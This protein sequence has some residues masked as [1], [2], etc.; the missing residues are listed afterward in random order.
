MRIRAKISFFVIPLTMLPLLLVGLY[1]YQSL[2]TGFEE[3]AY[4]DDQQ[5]CLM[6][7]MRIEQAL[8]ECHDGLSLLTTLLL[9]HL[10]QP[11]GQRLEKVIGGTGN[12]IKQ[13]AQ[14]LAVRHSPY[15]RIRLIAPEGRELFVAQG[16]K[17]HAPGSALNEPIFLQAVSTGGQFP[18]CDRDHQGSLETTFA[19]SL[20]HAPTPHNHILKGFVFLDLDLEKLS[21]ILRELAATRPG[22]YFLFDGAGK[23]LAEGGDAPFSKSDPGYKTYQTALL[24]ICGNPQPNF[25]HH[26]F[27]AAGKRFFVSSRPVK[28][29]IAFREP[30]PQERWYLAAVHSATPLLAAFH[31]SQ[32]L[33][34]A[35]LA[36]GLAIAVA[37][38]FY[39][40]QRLTTPLRR[41]ARAANAFAAGHLESHIAATSRDEIG[42]LATDFNNMATDLKQ[43]MRERQAN[44]T[45]IAVGK[46][47]AALAHDLRNPIEGLR[48]LSRELCKRVGQEQQE[49]EI[50]D[51]IVQ[52]V[53][54]LS[55]LVS[56]SLDFA[57]L[58]Q[59]VFAETDLAALADE[60]LQDFRF[61]EVELQKDYAPDLPPA[62]IDAAQI[63]RVLANLIRNA[64]E[65][66]LSKS[67][68]R[69][70]QIRL[71]LQAEGEKLRLEVADTGPGIAAEIR[72]KIF[73]PFFSTK[74]GGH[75]LGLALARQIVANHGGTI[76]FTSEMGPGT[77]FIIEL[78]IT[79]KS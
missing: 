20:V 30:I 79:T 13:T 50:A 34:L 7:A 17:E 28:E 21:K 38:T 8:D 33:F 10:S 52:S 45:L 58:N 4:L 72:E 63:K 22:Y 1:S 44:E 51:T 14:S 29:Y 59:P 36:I 12:A 27:D 6:A 64:L 48:L 74:P 53:E 16:L 9:P 75:G 56:Q 23:V 42:E 78:P 24:R 2:V 18:P 46:F 65:A 25:I 32:K 66:C 19:T 40:S 15:L 43:L 69:R 55:S 77:R 71:T 60:V 39:I 68:S 76:T 61:G 49:Y 37:G 41:L 5:L 54:R 47:S 70:G 73:D 62:K 57:R 67:D 11:D 3:Q 35:V 26:V 31:Q